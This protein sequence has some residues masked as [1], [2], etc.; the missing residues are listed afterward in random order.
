MTRNREVKACVPKTNLLFR[1]CQIGYGPYETH[2]AVR[3]RLEFRDRSLRG[4][5]SD[6]I[7]LR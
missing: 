3:C 7:T 2:F 5:D 4:D 6:G 1:K